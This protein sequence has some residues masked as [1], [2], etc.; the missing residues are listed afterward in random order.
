MHGNIN[1]PLLLN[2]FHESLIVLND[3]G[4]IIFFNKK[5]QE[6]ER[7]T[8]RPFSLG[9]SLASVARPERKIIVENALMLAS[10]THDTQVSEVEFNDSGRSYFLETTYDPICNEEDELCYICVLVRE[11]SHERI[12]QRKSASER[13]DFSRLIE[14][15]N[16]VIFS[17]D[18]MGY[19]TDW[20][21][22]CSR[23]TGF[24]KDET[25]ALKIH[26]LIEEACI[27]DF[28]SFFSSVLEGTPETNFEVLFKTKGGAPVVVLVNGTPKY[29]EAKKAV[30]VLFVGHDISELS[31]YRKNLEKKVEERTRELKVALEKEKQLVDIK[32]RFVSMAS[33]EFR[34]PL[35]SILHSVDTITA[36][37]PNALTRKKA[38]EVHL[39]VTHMRAMIDDV[40]TLDRSETPRIKA[41]T[42]GLE[43]ISFL[44][45]LAREVISNY[46]GSHTIRFS[47]AEAA[48]NMTSDEK[49]LRNIFINLFSN[50]IKFSPDA[51]TVDVR[52]ERGN[53]GI[54]ISVCDKG[55]GIPMEDRATL[56]TAFN[57]GSNTGQI[58]GTGLGLS[59]VKRA[60]HALQGEIELLEQDGPGTCF[61][62]TLKEK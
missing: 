18:A 49:L 15:A 4:E 59:I 43:L 28:I 25:L 24:E 9:V 48:I 47:S 33:H 41:N 8:T 38:E 58:K 30:G 54:I 13:E 29:N 62:V 5:V 11:R 16:A 42:S 31:S 44:N 36:S 32:N 10:R 61:R 34:M 21:A 37:H 7:F 27:P 23:I 22:E 3:R 2:N 19:I 55:I 20:N 57:R 45:D 51:D 26:P 35:M 12:I 53:G 40:I 39:Q 17:V 56:F 52:I 6:Y 60:V 14:S 50:A 46:H 1:F